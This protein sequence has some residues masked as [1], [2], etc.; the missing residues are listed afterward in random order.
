MTQAS[1]VPTFRTMSA[2]ADAPKD[3]AAEVNEPDTDTADVAEDLENKSLDPAEDKA[4]T[5]APAEPVAVPTTVTVVMTQHWRT[6]VPGERVELDH[7]EAGRLLN[8]KY[9]KLPA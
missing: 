2:H 7:R 5:A 8:Q 4:L 3:L 9:A 1:P 6:H